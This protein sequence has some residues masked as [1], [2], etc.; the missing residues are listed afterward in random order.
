MFE[1]KVLTERDRT[2]SGTFDLDALE[3]ALNDYA[4]DGWRLAEAFVAAN[5]AKSAKAEM[6]MILERDSSAPRATP[7]P[8]G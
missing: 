1:Y 6:V 5:F 3:A 8:A 2:F 7:V 4:S